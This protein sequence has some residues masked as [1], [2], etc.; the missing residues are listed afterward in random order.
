MNV[1]HVVGFGMGPH[2]LTWEAA[3]ALTE[4]DYVLA[5]RKGADDPLL[6]VRRGICAEFGLELV[7][8]PDPERERD[9]PRDY[10]GAVRDWHQARVAAFAD[11]I[12][13]R[14]GIG[15]FL[16]WGDPSL[17]DS[18]L[19]IV[20]SLTERLDLTGRVVPG[21]SAPQMLA[22]RHRVVL[23]DIGQPVHITTARRMRAEID[24][25]QRNLMV[26]LTSDPT[27]AE[28]ADPG[29]AEWHLW[30]GANLGAESEQLVAGRLGDVVTQLDAARETARDK[31][32]WVMDLFLLRAPED[33]R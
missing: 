2:H 31:A 18:T 8:V 27:L 16:V 13:E 12:Q 10:P 14:D 4:A 15:A 9:D 29:L 22:A 28:L 5:V 23:H 25:G 26:M 32:G 1:I 7:E 17:Y 3:E 11:E 20:D 30:W 21:I 19:R 24:A 33:A 6:E